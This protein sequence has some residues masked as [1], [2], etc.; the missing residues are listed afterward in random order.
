MSEPL[1]STEIFFWAFFVGLLVAVGL[2]ISLL[3]SCAT[4]DP[5]TMTRGCTI[6]L[7]EVCRYVLDHSDV[8]STQDGLQVTREGLENL[9]SRHVELLVPAFS[10]AQ[11]RCVVDVGMARIT[12]AHISSGPSIN[13]ADVAWVRNHGLCQ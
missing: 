4:A 6:N 13:A 7:R 11:L 5:P 10:G 12:D 3:T 9:S 1:E 8:V 2:L